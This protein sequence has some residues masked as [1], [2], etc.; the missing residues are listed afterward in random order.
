MLDEAYDSSDEDEDDVYSSDDVECS[1]ADSGYGGNN[2]P[3]LSHESRLVVKALCHCS[4]RE[5]ERERES[6]CVCNV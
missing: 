5:R 1:L 4:E 2:S 3:A 6:V